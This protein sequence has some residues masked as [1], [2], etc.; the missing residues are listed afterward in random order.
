MLHVPISSEWTENNV[1]LPVTHSLSELSSIHKRV[2]IAQIFIPTTTHIFALSD[3]KSLPPHTLHGYLK[4]I[5][6]L[7]Y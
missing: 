7:Y 6:G 5:N 3:V 1:A 4:Q 2:K